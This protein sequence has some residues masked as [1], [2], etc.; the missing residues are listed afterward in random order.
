MRVRWGT[1]SSVP[2]IFGILPNVVGRQ[3]A[4]SRRLRENWQG[5]STAGKVPNL[6]KIPRP[7]HRAIARCEFFIALTA[8]RYWL[9]LFHEG[10]GTLSTPKCPLKGNIVSMWNDCPHPYATLTCQAF[11]N[12]THH[13]WSR[14]FWMSQILHRHQWT[15]I[16]NANCT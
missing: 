5:A 12:R 10:S 7:K 13:S 9:K 1:F 14:A 16:C 6:K 2:T 4:S 15:N 3:R 11:P 8:F